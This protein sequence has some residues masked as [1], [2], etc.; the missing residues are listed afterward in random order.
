MSKAHM[1]VLANDAAI[2]DLSSRREARPGLWIIS[3]PAELMPDNHAFEW[4]YRGELDLKALQQF[5]NA[6]R[7]AWN[8]RSH[9]KAA[10][11]AGTS[12]AR[13][14]DPPRDDPGP[15]EPEGVGVAAPKNVQRPETSLAEYLQSEVDNWRGYVIDVAAQV[16]DLN[17]ELARAERRLNEAEAALAA[18]AGEGL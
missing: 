4:Q 16:D 12:P 13:I 2:L 10:K 11:E 3:A 17:A 15:S 18:I 6:T 7:E 9:R 5:C 1:E 8:E 14:P